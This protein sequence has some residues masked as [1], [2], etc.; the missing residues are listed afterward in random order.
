MTH[1]TTP[2]GAEFLIRPVAEDDNQLLAG[3]LRD[4]ME[5]FGATGAGSSLYDPE[6]QDIAS[7]YAGARSA[8]FV[9]ESTGGLVGGGGLGPLA[10]GEPDVCELRK[11]YLRPQARGRGLGR[12]VLTRCMERA[13]QLGYKR[14]YL[15]TRQ[16]MRDARR[17]YER[18]GFAPVGKPI[19][20]TGHFGCDA[21]YVREL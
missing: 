13:R 19:G 1:D 12:A 8:Y 20:H 15:E 18:N 3:L 4:V 17:L 6:L 7:A 10:G 16:S 21:W 2:G 14:M 11:M 5:E 9:V